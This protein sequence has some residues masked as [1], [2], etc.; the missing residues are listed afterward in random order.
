MTNDLAKPLSPEDLDKLL[1]TLD[2]LLPV[3]LTQYDIVLLCSYI[4]YRYGLPYTAAESV[5]AACLDFM[6]QRGS[7]MDMSLASSDRDIN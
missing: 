1:Y 3:R 7:M 6:K 5:Y 4:V 2:G